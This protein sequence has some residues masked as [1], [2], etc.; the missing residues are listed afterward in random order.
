LEVEKSKY[1]TLER[2]YVELRRELDILNI[3]NG[4]L[5]E[6]NKLFRDL[7]KPIL[8]RIQVTIV[9]PAPVHTPAADTPTEPKVDAA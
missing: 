3:K 8:D 6:N 5:E 9:Q 7:L 1:N 2:Q 4:I